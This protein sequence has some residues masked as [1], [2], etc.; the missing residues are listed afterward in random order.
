MVRSQIISIVMSMSYLVYIAVFGAAAVAYLWLRD[1]RVFYRTGLAGYRKS[2]YYGVF[3]TALSLTGVLFALRGLDLIGLGLILLALYL[4]G[5]IK[6]EKK[7]IWSEK[8][9]TADRILG[10]AERPVRKTRQK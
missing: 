8:S 1:A 10:K 4:Q 6:K 3:Y 9:T 5:G 2:A 7:Q